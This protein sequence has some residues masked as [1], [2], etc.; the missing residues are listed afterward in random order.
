MEITK[1]FKKHDPNWATVLLFFQIDRMEYR[2]L[3]NL[4]FKQQ[5]N[6]HR[7]IQVEFLFQS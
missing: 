5:K 7:K 1:N 6:P 4:I 2:K 3:I